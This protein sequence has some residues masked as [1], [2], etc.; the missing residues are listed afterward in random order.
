MKWFVRIMN[1]AA[2]LS[3]MIGGSMLDACI[4]TAT[5]IA[6]PGIAWICLTAWANT[7]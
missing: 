3:I 5:L 2:L 4:N 6:V 7:R 1:C